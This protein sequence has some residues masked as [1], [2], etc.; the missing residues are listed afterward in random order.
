MQPNQKVMVECKRIT[1]RD[2]EQHAALPADINY[3]ATVIWIGPTRPRND[4]DD[5]NRND[6]GKVTTTAA[7]E[8]CLRD[9]CVQG[10]SPG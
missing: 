4:R 10:S 1:E 8:I 3:R 6:P 5:P 2:R 9:V 7:V